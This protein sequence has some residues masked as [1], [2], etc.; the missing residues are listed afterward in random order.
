VI[1][2]RLNTSLS[3]GILLGAIRH[4]GYIPW[5]DD[6]DIA[7][8]RDDYEKFL[9]IAKNKLPNEF[10][11][12]TPKTNPEYSQPYAKV[13]RTNTLFQ[14]TDNGRMGI[15]I[16]IFPYDLNSGNVTKLK[17]IKN[18]FRVLCDVPNKPS[19]TIPYTIKYL[20]SHFLGLF[21]NKQ[22]ALI[23]ADNLAKK[24]SKRGS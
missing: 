3:G 13:V 9:E 22:S 6:L 16:D 10:K 4:E 11:L 2:I 17:W 5:D 15:F 7:M 20:P 23:K 8:P 1:V 19:N 12:V 18:L 14:K 21:I 24:I